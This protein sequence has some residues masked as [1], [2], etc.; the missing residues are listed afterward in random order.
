M[1]EQF[2]TEITAKFIEK[3]LSESSVNLYLAKAKKLNNGVEIKNLNFLKKTE[4]I[5]KQ[6]EA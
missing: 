2:K 3:G 4:D 1:S 5:K 6:L